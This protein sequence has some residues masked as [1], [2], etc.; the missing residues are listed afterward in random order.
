WGAGRTCGGLGPARSPRAAPPPPPPPRQ[1][2]WAVWDR[3]DGRLHERTA[4][5]R[6][7]VL[8]GRGAASVN[9]GAVRIELVLAEQAGIECVC[10]SGDAYAWSRK[11]GGVAASGTVALPGRP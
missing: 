2:F 10:R 3:R 8:L 9:A 4:L 7:G 5:G 6:G 11:Q 1:S